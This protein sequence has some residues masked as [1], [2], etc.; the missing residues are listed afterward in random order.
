[1]MNRFFKFLIRMYQIGISPFLPPACRFHPNCSEY[2][3]QALEKYSL[4][5]AFGLIIGRLLKCH[6]FH[7]GGY[8]P[9]K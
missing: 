8:D 3:C 9:L 7:E 4:F 2:S 1:M 6:P 5:R